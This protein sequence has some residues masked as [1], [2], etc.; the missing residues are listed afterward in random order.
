PLCGTCGA[1]VVLGVD[2][3]RSIVGDYETIVAQVMGVVK[4]G[5]EAEI[6]R[7]TLKARLKHLPIKTICDIIAPNMH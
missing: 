2:L 1:T 7:E 4:W 6:I 3:Q 5:A